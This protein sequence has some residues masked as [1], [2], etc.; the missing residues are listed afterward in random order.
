M[1]DNRFLFKINEEESFLAV[2][3]KND[4]KPPFQEVVYR[5]EKVKLEEQY[6]K[7]RKEIC[8]GWISNYRNAKCDFNDKVDFGSNNEIFVFMDTVE[9]VKEVAENILYGDLMTSK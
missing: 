6:I 4:E 2:I 9:K 5:I 8:S 1:E 7:S 3:E